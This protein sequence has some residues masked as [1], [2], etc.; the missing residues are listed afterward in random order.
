VQEGGGPGGGEASCLCHLSSACAPAIPLY[1]S[2]TFV[3][4]TDS[5][6]SSHSRCVGFFENVGASQ[7]GILL[8]THTH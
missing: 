7:D 1:P 3:Q 8:N 4:C 6:S 5:S 2:T